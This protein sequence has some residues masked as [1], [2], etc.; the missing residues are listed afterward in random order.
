MHCLYMKK[1]IVH[2]KTFTSNLYFVERVWVIEM[3]IKFLRQSY[4]KILLD[5]VTNAYNVMDLWNSGGST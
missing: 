1:L 3:L 5:K 2:S 4:P